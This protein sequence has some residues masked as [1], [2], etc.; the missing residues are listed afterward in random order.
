M[1]NIVK[2]F[3]FLVVSL[4]LAPSFA[5]AQGVESRRFGVG[6]NLGEPM[7]ANARYFF[8]D[9]LA[10]D[11]TVGY[12]FG[13]EGLIF[14]PSALFYFRDIA[15]YDGD[16]FSLVPYLGLGIKT[17]VDLAGGNDGEGI[18]ALR[19]P[20]GVAWV[21]KEGRLELN[22]EFGPGV[23]FSPETEFDVTGGVGIRYYFF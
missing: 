5:Q 15:D 10:A 12:G 14:Q 16:G 11:V 7:G 13:E 8:Y 21:I 4:T 18:F 2:F 23:E 9:F 1:K 17:G 3:V 22:A 19:F 6:V 20:I